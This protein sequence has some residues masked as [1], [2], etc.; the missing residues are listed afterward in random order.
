MS[1]PTIVTSGEGD[2]A[3]LNAVVTVDPDAL[4]SLGHVYADPV[5]WTRPAPPF[6]V[7]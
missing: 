3:A 2:D 5:P 4:L 6:E 7:A 1:V